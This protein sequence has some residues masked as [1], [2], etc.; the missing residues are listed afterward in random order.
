MSFLFHGTESARRVEMEV[1]IGGDHVA[2]APSNVSCQ[3]SS[4]DPMTLRLNVSGLILCEPVIDPFLYFV[5]SISVALLN[6]SF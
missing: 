4:S 1:K 2:T 5:F 6:F 3:S